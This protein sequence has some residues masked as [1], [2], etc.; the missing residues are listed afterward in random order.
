M[1]FDL[2]PYELLGVTK[3]ATEAE[4]KSVNKTTYQKNISRGH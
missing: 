2:Q 4:I 3:T 1:K